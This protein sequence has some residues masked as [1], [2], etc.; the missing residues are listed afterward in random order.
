MKKIVLILSIIVL[1]STIKAQQKKKKLF[2]D[3]EVSPY[4]YVINNNGYKTPNIVYGIEYFFSNRFNLKY[5][6]SNILVLNSENKYDLLMSPIGFG[7][8]YYVWQG[9]R[10]NWGQ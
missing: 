3:I 8:G 7:A 4:T 10:D 9:E 2:F 5:S 6:I 1:S